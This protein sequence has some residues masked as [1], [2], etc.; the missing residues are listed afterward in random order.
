MERKRH[1]LLSPGFCVLYILLLV[2]LISQL[3]LIPAV[4]MLKL[5]FWAGNILFKAII[6]LVMIALNWLLLKQVIVLKVTLSRPRLKPVIIWGLVL[7]LIA[8]FTVKNRTSIDVLQATVIGTIAAVPKEYLFRGVMLG[9]LIRALYVAHHRHAKYQLLFCI[10]LSSLIFSLAHLSNLPAQ[11]LV[12]TLAQVI[13]TLGM[14]AVFATLYIRYGSLLMPILIHFLI[15]FV[16][17]LVSGPYPKEA[18]SD[19][20]AITMTIVYAF[21]IAGIYLAIALRLFRRG[22]NNEKFLARLSHS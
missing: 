4:Y 21:L 17:T 12:I 7:I 16:I 6:L 18:P 15:D 2:V 10:G 22:Q 14:G 1:L 19:P 8:W 9:G 13:Q 5:D 11:G 3:L 20:N